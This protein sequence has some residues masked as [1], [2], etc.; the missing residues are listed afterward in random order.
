M[1]GF[2]IQKVN[3][4]FKIIIEESLIETFVEDLMPYAKFFGVTFYMGDESVLGHVVDSLEK[5]NNN[6]FLTN[7]SFDLEVEIEEDKKSIFNEISKD[8]WQ[9]ANKIALNHSICFDDIALYRPLELNYDK[10]RVSF[11]KG[12]FRGQEIIARMHYLGVNRRSFCAVIEN[13]EHPIEN[14]IKPLGEKLECENYKIYNC[15]IEQDIQ[16]E[17]LKSNKHELFTMP[18][19]QSD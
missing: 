1:A 6:S 7:G 17:L 11:T 8:K 16:N 5:S 9:I 12:C 14:N 10:L 2:L 4:N 13:T 15:F 3:K 18:T 19:N